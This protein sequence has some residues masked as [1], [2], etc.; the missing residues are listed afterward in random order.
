MPWTTLTEEHVTGSLAALEVQTLRT[1]Q[2]TPGAL[3]PL[4]ESMSQAIGKAID[5]LG[6]QDSIV[7]RLKQQV[8][9]AEADRLVNEAKGSATASG[10]ISKQQKD[11]EGI[12]E[13]E[14]IGAAAAAKWNDERE[15]TAKKYREL[16]DPQLKYK[17]QLEEIDD[18][19]K[20][21]GDDG[22]P[23]LNAQDAAAAKARV[24]A[25]MNDLAGK[26][27]RAGRDEVE[28]Y[29]IALEAL[30]KN[31]ALS[32]QEKQRARIALIDGQTAA[33][34]RAKEALT[35]FMKANPGADVGAITEALS[36]FGQQ[37]ARNAGLRQP[38][39]TLVQ[40]DRIAAAD[41]SDPSKHYQSAGDGL[42]GSMEQQAA[43]IGTVGDQVAR[44]WTNVGDSI[45]TSLG[46]A[47]ADMIL[48]AESFKDAVL[49]FGSAIVSSFIQNGAQM[50]A[51]W[52]YSH[53]IMAGIKS[54]F[55]TKD[56][57]EHVAGETVKT[58]VTIT[59]ETTRTAV[60]TGAAAT[61]TA[62]V[63]AEAGAIAVTTG[64]AGIFRSI[65][66]L[67][68]IAGPLVF[69][70]SIAGLIAMVG[71]VAGG[72][73]EGGIVRGPGTPTSDS[74]PAWLSNG[75]GVLNAR[76]TSFLGEDFVNAANSGALEL[77]GLSDSIG[78]VLPGAA[79]AAGAPRTSRK[80]GAGGAGG[81]A[82]APRVYALFDRAAFVRA[83]QEDSEAWFQDMSKT[84]ARKSS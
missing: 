63:T 3:D 18:L 73:A 51:D 58:A 81:G 61:N 6:K 33:I 68:P 5:D 26:A 43:A 46:G 32:D 11:Y 17:L 64:I 80:G 55:K 45:R 21:L 56:V 62:V 84:F 10:S 75:E 44:N 27:I 77:G 13:A 1:V 39:Q 14:A 8:A 69:A 12:A 28:K 59:G 57:A 15:E 23:F 49:G 34:E 16:A 19:T 22:K 79:D 7:E 50:V 71:A 41:V 20:R 54:I 76:A 29:D 74:I 67:G 70:A 52:L 2:L 36:R 37:S 30:D 60:I 82:G 48:R 9:S 38:A 40:R 47:L 24:L 83:M 65:M 4:P 31:P 53:T 72:F 42:A 25:E 78:S 66:E 35:A